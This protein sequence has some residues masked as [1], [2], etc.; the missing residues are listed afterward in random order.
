MPPHKAASGEFFLHI[1]LSVSS[2]LL[3]LPIFHLPSSKKK[4]RVTR[5]PEGM[6]KVF[7]THYSEWQ[8]LLVCVL[9]LIPFP[10]AYLKTN[11]HLP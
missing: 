7:K 8:G 5:C 10:Q 9:F 2:F 11:F 4:K 3:L 6:L 1:Y